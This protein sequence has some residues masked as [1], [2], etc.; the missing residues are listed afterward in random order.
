MAPRRGSESQVSGMARDAAPPVLGIDR[1]LTALLALQAAEREDRLN[2]DAPPRRT[3]VVLVDSGL[4][5][6]EVAQIT[7]KTYEG[8][9]TTV[10]RARDR[11]AA[12]G[13]STKAAPTDSSEGQGEHV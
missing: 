13:R 3:E 6:G 9:K 1:A 7:G 8:V 11:A 2:P 4:N 10:R 12:G 5:Y